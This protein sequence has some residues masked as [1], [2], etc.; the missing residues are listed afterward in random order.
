MIDP[1]RLAETFLSLVQ[2]DSVSRNEAAVC[3][4]LRERLEALGAE[5]T[6]DDSAP[7]TGSN[8]GNLLA[9]FA[10]TVDVEPILLSAHMDTVE[11]GCGIQP[12]LEN[13]VFRSDGTTILGADDKSAIAVLL[14]ALH[15]IHENG[16]PHGPIECVFTVCEEIGLLGAKHLDMSQIRSRIGY[17]LDATDIHGIITRA[18]GAN[19][20]TYVVHGKDAHAGAAPEKGINAIAIAC[21]AIAG[22]KLGRIDHETTCNIGIIQGGLATNIVPNK[23]VVKGEVRSHDPNKLEDITK[24]MTAAF[25]HAV[26]HT[27][28]IPGEPTSVP[29]LETHIESDFVRTHL[30]D[31]HPVVQLAM[32]AAAELNMPLVTKTTGGGADANIFFGHGIMTGVLGTGM[33]D[34]HT[35]RESVALADMVDATRLLLGILRIHASGL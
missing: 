21:K 11:P 23:V 3:Q 16:I 9:R 31:D 19:K 4:V 5:T 2:I 32:A 29:S 18:P 27:Q 7:K 6:I 22:I 34:M 24:I 35:V 20:L 1:K 33:K 28:S 8:T 15:V 10:G 30:P 25:E 17:V 14:E 12:I 26:H 13:G